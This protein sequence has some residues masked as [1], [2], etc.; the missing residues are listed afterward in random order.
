MADNIELTTEHKEMVTQLLD[1]IRALYSQTSAPVG[2]WQA[3]TLS[4]Q[5]NSLLE[6]A[7]TA[8]QPIA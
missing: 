7:S 3:S 8:I 5:V 6:L 1:R 4:A 2:G